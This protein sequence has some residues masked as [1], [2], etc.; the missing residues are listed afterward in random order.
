MLEEAIYKH[1]M[2]DGKQSRE[3]LEKWYKESLM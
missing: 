1:F 2:E 3:T